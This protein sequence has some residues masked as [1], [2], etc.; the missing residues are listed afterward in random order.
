MQ[1]L[2][3]RRDSPDIFHRRLVFG[4]LADELLHPHHVVPAVELETAILKFAHEP[5]AVFFVEMAACVGHV[6]VVGVA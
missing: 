6:L 2:L 3:Q 4:V 5:V 1:I